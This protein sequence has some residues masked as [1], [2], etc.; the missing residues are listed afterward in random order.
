MPSSI[1]AVTNLHSPKQHRT[2]PFSPRLP[3]H[4]LFVGFM[5]MATVPSG[6]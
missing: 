3:L 6:R 1:V 4:F 2:F 5:M